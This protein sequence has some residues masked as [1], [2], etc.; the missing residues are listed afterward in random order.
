VAGLLGVSI[1][2]ARAF[3]AQEHGENH[4]LQHVLSSAPNLC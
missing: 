1:N 4:Q 2:A 3:V